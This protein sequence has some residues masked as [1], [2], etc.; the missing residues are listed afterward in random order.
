MTY[1]CC[2]H[3]YSSIS[4]LKNYPLSFSHI[5]TQECLVH[6]PS[7]NSILSNRDRDSLCLL[8]L[9]KIVIR[10]CFFLILIFT[11]RVYNG[12]YIHRLLS[13]LPLVMPSFLQLSCLWNA[14]EAIYW[15]SVFIAMGEK[16]HFWEECFW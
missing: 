3:I 12:A 5:C 1:R 16:L 9:E 6:V 4:L 13:W 8:D 2:K 15:L 7:L 14:G 11:G 10:L